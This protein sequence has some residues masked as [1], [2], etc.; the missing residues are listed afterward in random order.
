[1]SGL[2]RQIASLVFL[3]TPAEAFEFTDIP[4]G[5]SS[6]LVVRGAAAADGRP[7]QYAANEQWTVPADMG[8]TATAYN[9]EHL[10]GVVALFAPEAGG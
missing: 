2:L 10:A 1:M 6:A 8:Q 3:A 9:A 5:V 7:R 4:T